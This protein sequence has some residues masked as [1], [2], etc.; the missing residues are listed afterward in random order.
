[1]VRG[2]G[3]RTDVRVDG[4]VVGTDS[5]SNFC[6]DEASE[7]RLTADMPNRLDSRSD[8]PPVGF[9]RQDVLADSRRQPRIG[10]SELDSPAAFRLQQD[11][12]TD[13]AVLEPGAVPVKYLR[14]LVRGKLCAN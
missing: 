9:G 12:S 2:R 14:E 5:R 6:R 7:W 10:R 3:D 8:D 11:R 13:E 1:M 4:V